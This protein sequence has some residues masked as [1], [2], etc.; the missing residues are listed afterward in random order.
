MV[1]TDSTVPSMAYDI[2]DRCCWQSLP[3]SEGTS[4][5]ADSV[6][7]TVDVAPLITASGNSRLWRFSSPQAVHAVDL[8][9]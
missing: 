5:T 4:L 8:V 3:A 9:K 6:S 1:T 7:V 2:E